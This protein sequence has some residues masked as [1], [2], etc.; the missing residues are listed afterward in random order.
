MQ[1]VTATAVLLLDPAHHHAEV[2]GLDHH[3]HAARLD[4][5]LDRLGDL[6]R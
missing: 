3:P 4:R 5:V 6:D 2:H 1:D